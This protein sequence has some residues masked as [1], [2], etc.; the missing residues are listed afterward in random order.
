MNLI[1]QVA[2]GILSFWLA[3]K[4]VPGVEFTGETKYLLLAGLVLGLINF[5]I[6][7]IL[8]LVTLPLRVITFGLFSLIINM[9]IIWAVDI[10]F[11]ELIISGLIPLFWTTLIVWGVSIFFGLSSRRKKRVVVEE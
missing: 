5:F 2:G 10:V 7:P 1:F 3:I 9:L 6:K 4:F 8:K 11:P